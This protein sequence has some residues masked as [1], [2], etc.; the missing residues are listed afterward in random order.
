M[1][2]DDPISAYVREVG[3]NLGSMTPE[4]ARLLE[5]VEGHLR[6]ATTQHLE[7]GESPVAAARKAIEEFGPPETVA[8]DSDLANDT[9]VTRPSR[10]WHLPM[11]IPFA[12]ATPAVVF[13]L[14]TL[15]W[16]PNSTLGQRTAMLA[17]LRSALLLSTLAAATW[18]VHRR[19]T[20]AA[21]ALALVNLVLFLGSIVTWGLGL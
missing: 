17:S 3:R 9:G 2:V 20:S 21:W 4:K 13:F 7:R 10:P 12:I 18:A 16:I 1:K 8:A 19:S 15:R 14:T 6:D 11:L 5:E